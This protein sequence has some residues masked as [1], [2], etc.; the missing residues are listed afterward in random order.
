[1]R[2]EDQRRYVFDIGK[3]VLVEHLDELARADLIA[4]LLRVDIADDLVGHA[5]IGADN[6]EE[7]LIRLRRA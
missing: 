3:V 5:D 2:S 6:V 1:M 7:F 4:D